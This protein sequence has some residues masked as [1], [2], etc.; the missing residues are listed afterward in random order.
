[1]TTTPPPADPGVPQRRPPRD[2][3]TALLVATGVLAAIASVLFAG[4]AAARHTATT[5]PA[6]GCPAGYYVREVRLEHQRLE[7]D[8]DPDH[9]P[10]VIPNTWPEDAAPGTPPDRRYTIALACVRPLTTR[11]RDS[12]P[13][14]DKDPAR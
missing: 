1:M 8:P 11:E 10:V 3:P 14:T 2:I 4:A 7:S 9:S 5:S 12:E 13:Y 6:V